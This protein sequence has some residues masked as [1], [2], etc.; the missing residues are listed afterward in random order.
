MHRIITTLSIICC[1]CL[2]SLTD[3]HAQVS[4]SFETDFSNPGNS[5]NWVSLD[6]GAEPKEFIFD[7]SNQEMHVTI[8]KTSW[9]F[10]QLWVKPFNFQQ[11]PYISFDIKTNESIEINIGVK[12]GD[13]WQ[14]DH[15]VTDR[16]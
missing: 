11:S 2:I 3:L 5:G 7:V 10:V 16:G 1:I 14:L 13:V 9:H 4:T 15:C 12:G 6:E 8:D